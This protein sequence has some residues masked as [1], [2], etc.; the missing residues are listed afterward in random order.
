M[1]KERTK[2]TKYSA[3]EYFSNLY[4]LP[5][6]IGMSGIEL[7]VRPHERNEGLG[8]AQVDDIVR[9]TRQHMDGLDLVARDL[10]LPY[11]VAADAAL[12]DEAV[13]R[14][15]DEEF[16]LAVMPMLPFR[17][18]RLGD[19]HAELPAIL[20]LEKLGEASARILV[21]LEGKGRLLPG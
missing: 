1:T 18:A 13:P 12:L 20:R 19:V 5:V 11:L 10:E 15:D 21:H 7:L 2:A 6:S 9:E 8:I 3:D 14:D 17:D 16:P 4:L